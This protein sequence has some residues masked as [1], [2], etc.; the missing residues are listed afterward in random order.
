M[1]QEWATQLWGEFRRTGD[2]VKFEQLYRTHWL[3][4]FRYCRAVLRDDE[5]ADEVTSRTF[6]VLFIGRPAA[7]KS[8]H[9]LL[10]TWASNLCRRYGQERRSAGSPDLTALEPSVVPARD[11]FGEPLDAIARAFQFLS[12]EERLVFILRVLLGYSW[13]EIGMVIGRSRWTA[14]RVYNRAVQRLREILDGS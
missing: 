1:N 9:L 6:V 11:D 12:I 7:R 5:L 3:D 13:T 10:F 14:E 2:P 8:F 4:V